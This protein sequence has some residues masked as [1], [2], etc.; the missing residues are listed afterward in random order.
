MIIKGKIVAQSEVVPVAPDDKRPGCVPLVIIA[1]VLMIVGEKRIQDALAII[2]V[3]SFPGIK[4]QDRFYGPGIIGVQAQ[5][6]EVIEGPE[7]VIFLRFAGSNKFAPKRPEG[8][9]LFAAGGV[10]KK[11]PENRVAI[12]VLGNGAGI[13]RPEDEL[14]PVPAEALLIRCHRR[15]TCRRSF[16]PGKCGRRKKGKVASWKH[17]RENFMTNVLKGIIL[18]RVSLEPDLY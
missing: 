4:G 10:G 2:G 8:Q 16:P 13:Q 7:S 3:G 11:R 15:G 5:L 6:L 18:K 9:S 14:A 12:G 17:L 1:F